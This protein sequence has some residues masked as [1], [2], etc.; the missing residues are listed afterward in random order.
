[1]KGSSSISTAKLEK[2]DKKYGPISKNFVTVECSK[3]K[4]NENANIGHLS[5]KKLK[6]KLEKIEVKIKVKIKNNKN[7]KVAI[8]K[9]NNYTN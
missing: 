4:I 2:L 3:T 5:N 6:D 8:N 9:L 1:M 7:G